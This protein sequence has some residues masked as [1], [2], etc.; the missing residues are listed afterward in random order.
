VPGRPR[1]VELST[2]SRSAEVLITGYL[3]ISS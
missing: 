2:A 3:P 1:L